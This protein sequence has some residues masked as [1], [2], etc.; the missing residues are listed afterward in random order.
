M[1]KLILLFSLFS[2]IFITKAQ[3]YFGN[4]A[5]WTEFT[6]NIN[7]NRTEYKS[8]FY[9]DGDTILNGNTYKKVI[10]RTPNNRQQPT[11]YIGAIR[12]SAGKVYANLEYYKSRNIGEFLLYD[13]TVKVGDVIHSIAVEGELSRSQVV[14]KIDTIELLTGEKRKKIFFN[15]S[16]ENACVEGI[17]C[18]EGLFSQA[19]EHLT[20]YS[21][22]HLVCYE[23]GGIQ[24]YKNNSLCSDGTCCDVLTGLEAPKLL[25]QTIALSPNPTNRFVQLDF[26]KSI[27]RCKSI[28]LMDTLGNTLQSSTEIGTSDF[29]LDLMRYHKG[30][31]FVV[32]EFEKNYE[33]YK[34]IKQ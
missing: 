27:N 23:Q 4:N 13:F 9:L 29:K 21:T 5:S 24:F 15:N 8:Q 17:G 25:N 30:L 31:Y 11:Y 7:T 33:L 16:V 14:T 32:I 6:V 28:K 22:T 20:N 19:E 10:G 18:I 12:E 3:S 34:V 2:I 1:K 26:S